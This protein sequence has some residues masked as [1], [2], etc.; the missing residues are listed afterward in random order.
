VQAGVTRATVAALTA[1]TGSPPARIR[2]LIGPAISGCC[3]ELPAAL[4]EDVAATEPAARAV[5][6]WGTPSLDLPAA[7][8]AQLRAAGVGRIG[9]VQACTRCAPDQWFSHRAAHQVPGIP[10]GRNATVIC[11]LVRPEP[12]AVARAVA[13]QRDLA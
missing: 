4:A 9:R 8:R 10:S 6:S 2:A 3:Y 5:T 11:R 12:G 13:R 1:A 7:V